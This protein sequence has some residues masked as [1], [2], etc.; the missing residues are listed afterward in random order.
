MHENQSK[1]SSEKKSKKSYL[2]YE[3]FFKKKI[4]F[5]IVSNLIRKWLLK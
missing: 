4:N 5:F 3:F 1:Y 2:I